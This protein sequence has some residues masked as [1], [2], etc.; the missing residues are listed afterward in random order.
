MTA[1][2]SLQNFAAGQG[3]GLEYALVAKCGPLVAFLREGR[4]LP[5]SLPPGALIDLHHTSSR[6]EIG[7][8]FRLRKYNWTESHSATLVND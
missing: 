1:H 8:L 5:G 6:L 3:Q 7:D 2:R 4:M